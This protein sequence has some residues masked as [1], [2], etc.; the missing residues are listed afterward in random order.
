M[1]FICKPCKTAADITTHDRPE[2]EAQKAYAHIY[3]MGGTW[4]DCQHR[5]GKTTQ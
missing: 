1:Q 3:C 5:K 4:C 2:I